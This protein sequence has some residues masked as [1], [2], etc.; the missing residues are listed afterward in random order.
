MRVVVQRVREASVEVGGR[1]ISSIGPGVVVLAAFK[2]GDTDEDLDWTA[3]KILELRI[4]EDDQGKMNRSLIDLS[5]EV[6]VISQFTLYGNCRKGRRPAYS[7]SA[8]AEEAMRLYRRF[9][10]ISTGYY[11][12]VAEGEF[13]AHMNVSLVND[14]PVTLLIDRETEGI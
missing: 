13:G 6:L 4:F 5:G 7:G 1:I 12:R 11:P 3:R 2:S 10:E 14:G 9:I 8:P